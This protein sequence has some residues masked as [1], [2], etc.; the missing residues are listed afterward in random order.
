MPKPT[1]TVGQW[2]ACREPYKEASSV[3]RQ[4]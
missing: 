2:L 4:R 1:E 3:I